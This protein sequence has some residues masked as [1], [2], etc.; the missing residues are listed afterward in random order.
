MA[1]AVGDRV[2]YLNLG[3]VNLG[4]VAE[5]VDTTKY[6]E[7][8]KVTWDDGFDDDEEFS[9]SDDGTYTSS[10]LQEVH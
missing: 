2:A 10:E 9:L 7:R 1:H 4:T 5:V 3:Y 6:H 8:Y